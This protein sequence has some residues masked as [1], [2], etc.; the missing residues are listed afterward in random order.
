MKDYLKGSMKTNMKKLLTYLG[1]AQIDPEQIR[2]LQSQVG[3]RDQQLRDLMQKQE[4]AD[5][6]QDRETKSIII[7]LQGRTRACQ[8]EFGRNYVYKPPAGV[9]LRDIKAADF[10]LKHC[11]Q[12][13]GM[14]RKTRNGLVVA[15]LQ[16]F[17]PARVATQ[18]ESPTSTLTRLAPKRTSRRAKRRPTMVARPKLDVDFDPSAVALDETFVNNLREKPTETQELLFQYFRGNAHNDSYNAKHDWTRLPGHKDTDVE[19]PPTSCGKSATG[20]VIIKLKLHHAAAWTQMRAWAQRQGV[21]NFDALQTPKGMLVV[22]STGSGKTFLAPVLMQA[23]WDQHRGEKPRPIMMFTTPQNRDRIAKQKN[24]SE[25]WLGVKS[26]LPSASLVRDGPEAFHKRVQFLSFNQVGNR[27]GFGP[28]GRVDKN[29]AR[30]VKDAFIIMDEVQAIFT[31][32][33]Q[34]ARQNQGVRDWLDSADADGIT[35][36]VMTATPGADQYELFDILNILRRANEKLQVET[37]FDKKTYSIT[38]VDDFKTRIAQQVSFVDFRNNTNDYPLVY[39]R[40]EA[41]PMSERQFELWQTR[42][43]GLA[44]ETSKDLSKGLAARKYANMIGPR[45]GNAG[46]VYKTGDLEKIKVLSAKLVRAVKNIES[47]IGKQ[48]LYSAFNQHGVEQIAQ[49][50]QARGWTDVTA[51]VG[52]GQS[53]PGKPYQRFITTSKL[54][55]IRSAK[56]SAKSSAKPSAKP[57]EKS[58]RGPSSHSSPSGRRASG[59]GNGR[60]NRRVRSKTSSPKPSSTDEPGDDVSAPSR[61]EQ[62]QL[63]VFVTAYNAETNVYGAEIALM[64]ATAGHNVG[65]DLK[66]VRAMHIFEPLVSLAQETQTV[67]RGR[68]YCSHANLPVEHRSMLVTHYFSVVG[69]QQQEIA[70]TIN[71]LAKQAHDATS[72]AV[73]ARLRIATIQAE[74]RR[75]QSEAHTC[76]LEGGAIGFSTEK[77]WSAVQK[78][79]LFASKQWAALQ[80]F[81]SGSDESSSD[82]ASSVVASSDVAS[83]DVARSDVDLH[84]LPA[85]SQDDVRVALLLEQHAL[86]RAAALRERGAPMPVQLSIQLEMARERRILLQGIKAES[87]ELRAQLRKIQRQ[88]DMARTPEEKRAAYTAAIKK[89]QELQAELTAALDDGA[90]AIAEANA[91][92]ASA[93]QQRQKLNPAYNELLDEFGSATGLEAV[94]PA[95]PR[96]KRKGGAADSAGA[97]DADPPE[98]TD[99]IVHGISRLEGRPMEVLLQALADAAFDCKV[100]QSMHARMGVNVSCAQR[101]AQ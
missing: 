52:S 25:Y 71:N 64:L 65:L 61:A 13:Y 69:T 20:S 42:V 66:E 11:E 63:A 88:A 28:T 98:S 16:E 4:I 31:P 82:V 43:Q 50:L 48:Y 49:V 19:L 77:V 76:S 36:V 29:F 15:P 74:I 12:F 17:L 24:N 60:G 84:P 1:E 5:E 6:L 34:Y 97:R 54:A 94:K 93:S 62:Q 21:A 78:L 23:V 27:L 92:R 68:R 80:K 46:E 67:G 39:P 7:E 96:G 53:L 86:A 100:L 83:S 89:S 10:E 8:Q 91:L 37:Y 22:H 40:V 51:F 70:D 95:K 33:G 99:I 59:R 35:L 75:V 72:R 56:P 14:T 3:I 57:S 30:D 101:R 26:M 90:H 87:T 79:K 32:L 45:L 44:L 85:V 9:A 2:D 38:N 73:A 81:T 18:A 41:V 58:K 55:A 47:T